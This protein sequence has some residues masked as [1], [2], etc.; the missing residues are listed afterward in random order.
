MQVQIIK[1]ALCNNDV[2]YWHIETPVE[3][4]IKTEYYLQLCVNT[5]E[6]K[7]VEMYLYLLFHF[8]K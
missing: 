5:V 6:T 2:E 1:G 3:I 7:L 4:V 8:V